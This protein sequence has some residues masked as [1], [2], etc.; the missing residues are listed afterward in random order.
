MVAALHAAELPAGTWTF[1]ALDSLLLS[2]HPESWARRALWATPPLC[3]W[4][5]PLCTLIPLAALFFLFLKKPPVMIITWTL[6]PFPQV[7]V[8]RALA[9]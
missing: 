9:P 4:E 2:L 1:C 5:E 7:C 8:P 3:L 6:L